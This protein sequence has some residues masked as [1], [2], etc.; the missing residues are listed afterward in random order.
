[1][2]VFI[3]AVSV[4]LFLFS[5]QSTA[6]AQSG[7]AVEQ[8]ADASFAEEIR[9]LILAANPSETVDGGAITFI[10]S[11]SN[12]TDIDWTWN[13]GDGSPVEVKSGTGQ[14]S[15]IEHVFRLNNPGQ[16]QTYTVSVTA[17]NERNP[18][19]V[20][21]TTT[22]NIRVPVPS[23]LSITYTPARPAAQQPIQF[24]ANVNSRAPVTYRWSFSDGR[25]IENGAASV[26]HIFENQG[27]FEVGVTATNVGGSA[28]TEVGLV[29]GDAPIT[30]CRIRATGAQTVGESL[31]FTAEHD[32]TNVTYE[33]H[34]GDGAKKFSQT[35]AHTYANRGEYEVKLFCRNSSL[36]EPSDQKIIDIK[37]VA[38]GIVTLVSNSAIESPVVI[39]NNVLLSAHSA[40]GTDVRYKWDFGDGKTLDTKDSSV[41]HPYT[42]ARA[43]RVT[44]TAYNDRGEATDSV[45]VRMIDEYDP[46]YYT[47]AENG[48]NLR[49]SHAVPRLYGYFNTDIPIKLDL[50]TVD[51]GD[52]IVL[53]GDVE[54]DWFSEAAVITEPLESSMLAVPEAT[55]SRIVM[56]D[57]PGIYVETVVI[58]SSMFGREITIAVI[59]E[60]VEVGNRIT[61]P[62]FSRWYTR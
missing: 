49:V 34:L 17:S 2:L 9:G 13:F 33:W 56:Y 53:D 48:I 47:K 24:T 27:Y 41:E 57:E 22:V 35:F 4:P 19:G 15:R 40:K 26:T 51:D 10:A 32:G 18:G 25:V 44:V 23:G 39:G 52:A 54:I 46:V 29:V 55:Q 38:P 12:G 8:S 36:P 31:T 20:K 60:V 3:Q 61:M 11:V 58:T 6:V 43:Y 42:K 14:L 16:E 5:T 62:F 7:D 1:M 37:N 21:A 28:A 59:N 50:V 30:Y 45:L